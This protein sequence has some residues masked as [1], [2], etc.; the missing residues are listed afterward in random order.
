MARDASMLERQRSYMARDA[1]TS[2]TPM[3]AG[4]SREAL[5]ARLR[6]VVENTAREDRDDKAGD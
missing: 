2:R 3:P 1:R 6:D 4:P 5:R